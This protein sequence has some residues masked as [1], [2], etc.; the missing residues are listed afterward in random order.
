MKHKRFKAAKDMEWIQPKQRGYLMA[1]CDCGL[2][3]RMDF[4][5]FKGIQAGKPIEKVQLRA[6]RARNYTIQE[7]RK[8][9]PNQKEIKCLNSLKS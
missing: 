7:R 6:T 1:C 3:H 2:V 4:R 8:K 5:I 9:Q